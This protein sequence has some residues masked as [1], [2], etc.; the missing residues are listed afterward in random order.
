MSD[1]Q[2]WA[3]NAT[4]AEIARALKGR[5]VVVLTHVR[6]DG[7]AIGSTLALTRALNSARPGSA[8]A[9]YFGPQPLWFKEVARDAPHRVLEHSTI[10]PPGAEAEP[11]VIAIL[12]TGSWTQLEP[13]AGWLKPRADRT[14]IVDHHVQGDPGVSDRRHVDTAAA[15]ACQPVSELC[16]LILGL[17]RAADLPRDIAEALYLGIAT[18]TGWF[19]HSNVSARVLRDAAD[20]LEAGV[21]HSELFRL[22]EQ[23]DRPARLALLGRALVT[24]R[25]D[26]KG[27]IASMTLTKKDFEEC[28]AAPGDSSG[29]ADYAQTVGSVRVVAMLTEAEPDAQGRPV[30]KVSLRSKN[31]PDSPDVNRVAKLFG[32]GGHVR[33]AGARIQAEI[34]EARR[35]VVEA[36]AGSTRG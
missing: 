23:Q 9:W 1:P 28:G 8:E 4:L 20:L 31:T 34:G 21:D 14:F 26:A 16:R 7:D 12:D 24:L 36:L 25:L 30:T 35:R 5:R 32:G 15:A 19:K 27:S 10:P 29:F 33:A 22:V 13:A 18:D 6:P 11:D 3:T 2:T 17:T